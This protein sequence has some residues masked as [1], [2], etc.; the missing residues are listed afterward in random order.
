MPGVASVAF[1][2]L[3]YVSAGL[4]DVE[5]TDEFAQNSIARTPSTSLVVLMLTVFSDPVTKGKL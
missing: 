3:A 2:L 1:L 4:T 5:L